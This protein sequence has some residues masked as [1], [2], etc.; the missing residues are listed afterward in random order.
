[1]GARNPLQR[2]LNRIWDQSVGATAL[3]MIGLGILFAALFMDVD[4][5]W[6]LVLALGAITLGLAV[7]V[8]NIREAS[9]L[10]YDALARAELF[11][12]ELHAG[13]T[14]EW[15]TEQRSARK[16]QRGTE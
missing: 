13:D 2:R 8:S 14:P 10:A 16:Q 5:A 15:L 6:P 12:V 7:L 1:M 4:K 11:D 3:V 9:E